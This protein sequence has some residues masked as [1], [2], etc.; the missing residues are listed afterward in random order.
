MS[1]KVIITG[2]AGFIGSQLSKKLLQE[3][4]EVHLLDD[5]SN[6]LAINIAKQAVLHKVDLSDPLDLF[7]L[8]VP[9]V[10]CIFHLAAQS[11][12]EASF[13]NPLRDID[14]NYRA[15]Y[16]ILRLADAKNCGR[17]IFS[18]SMS[19]YGDVP[20]GHGPV[21]EDYACNPVSYY[22]CNKLASEKLISVFTRNSGIKFTVFR[23]F[24]VYGP[25]QNMFN[26]KQGMVSIYL[27]YLMQDQPILVKGSLERFRDFIY[28]DDVL[29]ALIASQE[30]AA[31]FQKVFN[32]GTSVKTSVKE[33]L[34]MLLRIYQK[35]D[36]S[37][38][39]KV[40]GKTPGDITGIVADISKLKKE[41]GWQPKY[42]L[43]QG[44]INMKR[45]LDET[46]ELWKGKKDK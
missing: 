18:S 14:V 6:G 4:Y 25:G 42:N 38:W 17:V 27:S 34:D 8:D 46:A 33:L 5:F 3:G 39:V 40:D 12:G 37:K 26:L 21:A 44:L 41:T 35:D 9:D 32:L 2:G 7:K 15:T 31:T 16:N 23:P 43:E 45:W 19:V 13:E 30:N 24:N 28:I 1:K 29:N 36:F 10:N 22:G 20:G 11:S